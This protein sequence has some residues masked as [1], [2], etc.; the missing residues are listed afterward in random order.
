M[1]YFLISLMMAGCAWGQLTIGTNDIWRLK[2]GD[3]VVTN[4]TLDTSMLVTSSQ[5]LTWLS[6]NSYL[7][8]TSTNGWTVAPHQAWITAAQASSNY[9]P[10]A[11]GTMSG[12]IQM[13]NNTIIGSRFGEYA[14]DSA[15][16]TWYGA[17]GYGAGQYASGIAWNAFGFCAGQDA[18]GTSW[19]ALGNYAGRWA[20]GDNR[21]YI[22]VY[23]YDPDY[24]V[25][26]GATNDMIFGDNGYLYLGRGAGAPGGEKG[27]TLRGPVTIGGVTKTEWPEASSGVPSV[28]T[29]MTWGAVGT[30]S[31][32]RMSWDVTNG[33]FKVEEIVP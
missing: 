8:A 10:L 6:T 2:K 32:Y 25:P 5:W 20:A 15:S 12:N 22:D 26:G 9:L 31:T 1:W 30:N 3:I 23:D 17:W 11:G 33:T 4:V 19:T 14:G 24:G 13:G 27:V 29:N 18:S 28:W 7:T 16:G 21:L